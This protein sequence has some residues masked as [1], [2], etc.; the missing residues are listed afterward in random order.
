MRVSMC[1]QLL[2]VVVMKVSALS[3]E[4]ESFSRLHVPSGANNKSF[5]RGAP[6]QHLAPR[7]NPELSNGHLIALAYGPYITFSENTRG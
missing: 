6:M 2:K 1:D 7:R 5:P 4:D 3:F